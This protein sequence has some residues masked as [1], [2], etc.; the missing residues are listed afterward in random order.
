MVPI[1]GV[2]LV[3]LYLTE[4]I[5]V[6]LRYMVFSFIS[7]TIISTLFL[8]N[9]GVKEIVFNTVTT[10]SGCRFKQLACSPENPCST[11]ELLEDKFEACLIFG[12][13]LLKDGL[14]SI[15]IIL[16]F[17][18]YSLYN[19]DIANNSLT[20]LDKIKSF[21]KQNTW[22][23]WVLVGISMIPIALSARQK[24]GG[25]INHYGLVN[26][27]LAIASLLIIIEVILNDTL[28]LLVKQIARL[29]LLVILL[30]LSLPLITMPRILEQRVQQLDNNPEEVVYRYLKTYPE[31]VYF[32]E[33]MIGT[34][35]SID[36]IYHT[37]TG[38][39]AILEC[40]EPQ[41]RK[42]FL[43]HIP[44]NAQFI[45]FHPLDDRY[46]LRFLPEFNQRTELKELPGWIVYERKLE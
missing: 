16:A 24:E 28:P 4:G 39:Y 33:R 1:F 12:Q 30:G 29:S 27:F 31:N 22:M 3:Y 11:L 43:D 9:F 23:L 40:I 19:L 37:G 2:L 25:D 36:K 45:A 10:L 21:L 7:L 8:G 18:L 44:Q 35:M 41:N 5:Y 32:P 14:L 34:L 15:S 6:A 13:E 46:I 38:I 20:L 17:S 26:Y 42:Y